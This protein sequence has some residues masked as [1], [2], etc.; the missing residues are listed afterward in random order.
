MQSCYTVFKSGENIILTIFVNV[1]ILDINL[2]Y[3]QYSNNETTWRCLDIL[4]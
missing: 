4:V 3:S 1:D 2:S